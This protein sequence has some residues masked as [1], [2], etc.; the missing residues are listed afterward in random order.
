MYSIHGL[1]HGHVIPLVYSLLSDKTSASY[2]KLFAT[3]RDAM[4]PLGLVWNLTCFM[5][6]FEA[7]LIDPIR[8]QFPNADHL[9][10]HFH[11]GQ[12]VWRKVQDVGLAVSYKEIEEIWSFVQKC[13]AHGI[14]SN[15]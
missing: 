14:Y 6:D 13:I 15:P 12:A 8:Q 7:G 11:F 5:S 2:S 3:V 9:G 10:C 1:F 4:A